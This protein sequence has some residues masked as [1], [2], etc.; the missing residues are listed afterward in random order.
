MDRRQFISGTAAVGFSAGLF[1][2]IGPGKTANAASPYDLVAIK[3]GMPDK[4]FDRGMAAMG[5]MKKFVR[6]GQTVVVNPNIGWDVSPERAGN[7]NPKLVSRIIEHCYEAGAKKVYVFDN[8][9]DNWKKCYSTSGIERASKD[10]G[11]TVVSGDSESYYT[12]ENVRGGKI[13]K[14]TKVHELILDCDV[15]INVPVL[16]NHGSARL[17]IAMKNLMG[18]IWDRRWWHHNDLHQCIAD[19]AYHRRPD[20]NILDAYRV[21]MRHGP[22]GVSVEDVVTMK[23][24]LI[25]TDMVAMDAAATKLFG[26]DPSE[27]P[28]IKIA[29]SMKAGTMDLGKLNIKR[30]KV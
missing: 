1:N 21:M 18:I 10:A 7:T 4:M 28:Y 23:S 12:D 8:T 22:R 24:Q 9:C 16:K 5:G 17:T 13:L 3:G 15:Y 30:I 20:L 25:S 19:Y 11:A 2:I 27:I 6:K 29:D 26:K 14:K